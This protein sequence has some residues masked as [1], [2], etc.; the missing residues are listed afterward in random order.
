MK[1]RNI[2]NRALQVNQARER[3]AHHLLAMRLPA[4]VHKLQKQ[5]TIERICAK[6]S[7]KLIHNTETFTDIGECTFALK[8]H[9]NP[10]R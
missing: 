10:F 4:R 8:G 3:V 7:R 5:I 6:K 1:N 2:Q 9:C